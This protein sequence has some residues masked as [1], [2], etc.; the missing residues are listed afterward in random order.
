[1][2]FVSIE[3]DKLLFFAPQM[4]KWLLILPRK[5]TYEVKLKECSNEKAS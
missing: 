2:K 3:S 1:M 5:G 4:K